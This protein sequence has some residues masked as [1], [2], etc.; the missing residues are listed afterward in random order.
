M[1]NIS[2]KSKQNLWD[3]EETILLVCEYYRTKGLS[4]LEQQRSIEFLSKLLRK[5]AEM[6]EI[7]I[8]ERFRNITGIEMKFANMQALDEEVISSG[9]TGLKNVSSLDKEIVKEYIK[10]PEKINQ[11]AYF[12]IMKYI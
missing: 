5:R 6:L 7:C 4:K 2:P 8:N 9:H 12:I 10:C 3:K 11:E 1:T